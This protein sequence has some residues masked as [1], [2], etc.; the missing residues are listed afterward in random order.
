M[1]NARYLIKHDAYVSNAGQHKQYF[2]CDTD[3][4]KPSSGLQAGIDECY[5]LDTQRGYVAESASSWRPLP[6]AASVAGVSIVVGDD[7]PAVAAGALGKVDLT[8]QSASISS[9]NLTNG[10][11]VG[12]YL[13]FYEMPVTAFDTLFNGDTVTLAVSHTD[14]VGAET[15]YSAA[16]SFDAIARNSGV[17]HVSVESGEISYSTTVSGGPGTGRYALKLRVVALG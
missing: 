4:G 3:A 6:K 9:T 12:K 17:F 14:I 10:A 5:C 7:T 11:P 15:L 8:G 1:A 16:T 13:V 2:V